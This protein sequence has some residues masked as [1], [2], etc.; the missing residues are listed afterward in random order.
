MKKLFFI[1]ALALSSVNLFGDTV[2]NHSIANN[3]YQTL[4]KTLNLDDN[5]SKD[6]KVV[7]ETF[8][9]QLNNIDD[10]KNDSI[11]RIMLINAYRQ[12]SW[13]SKQFLNKDEYGKYIVILKNTLKNRLNKNNNN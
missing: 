2:K 13:L 6:F 1:C 11:K 7:Y 12:N 5:T 9:N 8:K 4:S 10:E 3:S